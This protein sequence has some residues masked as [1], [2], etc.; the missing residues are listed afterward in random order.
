MTDSKHNEPSAA[1]ELLIADAG[2]R[3]GA[4]KSGPGVERIARVDRARPGDYWRAR[5]AVNF[6]DR[7]NP[8]AA[9]VY[10]V[11]AGCVLLVSDVRTNAGVDHTVVVSRHPREKRGGT[12]WMLVGDFLEAFEFAPD[13]ADVR[14]RE[15]AEMQS[16]I[17]LIQVEI[18]RAASD[19]AYMNTLIQDALTHKAGGSEE[20]AGLPASLSDVPPVDVLTAQAP[21]LNQAL[22]SGSTA[23]VSQAIEVVRSAHQLATLQGEWFGEQAAKIT[24]VTQRMTPF[25]LERAEVARART[26]GE[27]AKAQ[28]LMESVT[29]MTLFAGDGVTCTRIVDGQ[30]APAGTPI[31]LFQAKRWADEDAA[32]L[33]QYEDGIDTDEFYK[34]ADALRTD[35]R[36]RT[37]LLPCERGAVLMGVSRRKVETQD[38]ME[39][40]LRALCI[41]PAN[42]QTFILVRD[43]ERF[44][45]VDSPI[46]DHESATR[47]FPEKDINGSIFGGID[48]DMVTVDDLRW[49]SRLDELHA[50]AVHYR[51]WALVLSGLVAREMFWDGADFMA[52]F[53]G[54]GNNALFQL[55]ADDS[56]EGA[57]PLHA[58]SLQ[59]FVDR[60]NSYARAGSLLFVSLNR[61]ITE[62]TTS[63]VF[64]EVWDRSAR[65][66]RTRRHYRW[67]EDFVVATA[68]AEGDSLFIRTK[69]RHRET[70]RES[71]IR[72]R[73][74][75]HGKQLGKGIVFL[76]LDRLDTDSLNRLMA[77]RHER[78]QFLSY[79]KLFRRARDYAERLEAESAPMVE[80]LA[81][82]LVAASLADAANGT[83]IATEALADWRAGGGEWPVVSSKGLEKLRLLAF[84]LTKAGAVDH[85]EVEALAV[86][87]GHTPLRLSLNADG[88]LMLL[89][90]DSER[91]DRLFLQEDVAEIEVEVGARGLRLG[92]QGL[93]LPY[94]TDLGVHVLREWP[95][96]E[97]VALVRARP[98][99]KRKKAEMLSD[100]DRRYARGRGL[101]FGPMTE[102]EEFAFLSDYRRLFERANRERSSY[103][104]VWAEVPLA[105]VFDG[106]DVVVLGLKFNP[107]RSVA[108]LS[109]DGV[110]E[111]HDIYCSRAASTRRARIEAR[112]NWNP[113]RYF[114]TRTGLEDWANGRDAMSGGNAL[115]T[116]E[117][118]IEVGT[119]EVNPFFGMSHSSNKDVRHRVVW[120][121]DSK[122]GNT[123]A[124]LDRWQAATVGDPERIRARLVKS[125]TDN[126][127]P[128]RSVAWATP[129]AEGLAGGL[130][131]SEALMGKER[132]AAAREFKSDKKS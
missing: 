4:A 8:E 126:G 68:E 61:A 12:V 64:T 16:E 40:L 7:D 94:K 82:E 80:K 102:S 1:G 5:K 37:L 11:E 6:K 110:R 132:A 101:M 47:F 130:T 39:A 76:C 96:L 103:T 3:A 105:L 95:A 67:E 99:T 109:E 21:T 74:T 98:L 19:P 25:L 18:G 54:A 93:A 113:D 49:T 125:W 53:T 69:V 123:F 108:Y 38:H 52:F 89:V 87:A 13:G 45:T 131:V 92:K 116:S 34:F 56:G 85:A 72:V 15:L 122:E 124:Q 23:L 57:L 62:E 2:S 43:G 31:K 107:T 118:R 10:K 32:L 33:T 70:D 77:N 90:P 58:E 91:D 86:A 127:G 46:P 115:N 104:E 9:P 27:L 117:L 48:G 97:S 29:T 121:T 106:K 128:I 84:R 20:K 41:E 65:E 59:Q 22:A 81:G 111:V 75:E 26:S 24:A 129:I 71:S 114:V 79:L 30:P 36:L 112:R 44:Y 14:A 17:S 73:M 51:R 35:E 63:K 28:R 120:S 119:K 60:N 50:Q 100:I 83:R 66:H 55:V 88:K 42:K 78:S